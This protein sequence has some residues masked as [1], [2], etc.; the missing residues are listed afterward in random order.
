MRFYAG[1]LHHN[2]IIILKSIITELPALNGPQISSNL[3]PFEYLF[4]LAF[5]PKWRGGEKYLNLLLNF[6]LN[7][8]SSLA[9]YFLAT[10]STYGFSL[11]RSMPRKFPA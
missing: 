4:I 8:F 11:A 2:D 1:F 3:A 7:L 10:H 6:S 5:K 9:I